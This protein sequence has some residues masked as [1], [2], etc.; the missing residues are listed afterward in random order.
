MVYIVHVIKEAIRGGPHRVAVISILKTLWLGGIIWLIGKGIW[1]SRSTVWNF[2]TI[3]LA[4][5]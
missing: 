4:D 2:W 1:L 3:L 5:L